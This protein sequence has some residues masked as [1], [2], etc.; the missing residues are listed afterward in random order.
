V[1]G[2]EL[3]CSWD[4]GRKSLSRTMKLRTRHG[5]N[6]RV[7]S[8]LVEQLHVL[9]EKEIAVIM[10]ALE[11]SDF[12]R[13]QKKDDA[14]AFDEGVLYTDVGSKIHPSITKAVEMMATRNEYL[15]THLPR[16]RAEV[17]RISIVEMDGDS[18]NR[19][20]TRFQPQHHWHKDGCDPLLTMV[21]VLYD[22]EWDSTN[23]PGAFE[24]GG[25]VAL[26]DRPC[27]NAVCRAGSEEHNKVVRSGRVS[28][29]YPKTNG[30][31][32]IPGFVVEHAVF[33]VEVPNVKRQAIVVFVATKKNYTFQSIRM[34]AD[35]YFR[36][37]W[38]LGFAKGR[39]IFC[40]KC[41]QVF[42]KKRQLYDHRKRQKD[43]SARRKQRLA[44][45]RDS[46]A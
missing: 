43:C 16:G 36:L 14:V 11:S 15:K 7:P 21:Y 44:Y 13:A 30:L 42:D 28:T 8:S 40:N 26:A 6:D 2:N 24:C 39:S 22:G 37:T 12:T 4:Y 34:S 38:A 35:T 33:K 27:G 25:R 41:Y 20:T 23:S 10:P 46:V 32:I 5:P 3:D 29:Y 18:T 45:E 1:C 17:R 31:Y 19:P 9:T